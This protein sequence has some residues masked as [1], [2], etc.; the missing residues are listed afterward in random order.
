MADTCKLTAGPSTPAA[1]SRDLLPTFQ[2]IRS[3]AGSR[4]RL[5][6]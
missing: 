5:S 4:M 2:P 1:K 3:Q 6:R